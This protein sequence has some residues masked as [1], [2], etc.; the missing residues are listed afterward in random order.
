MKVHMTENLR[1]DL[2]SE[3]WECR[4]CGRELVCARDN[5][6]RG[7]NVYERDPRE[8]HAPI[9]D[10]EKYDFTFSPDPEWVRILE[11]YCP[12]CGTQMEVEYLP[13]GHPPVH[14]IDLDLDA[15]KRQWAARE[16]LPEP[17]IAPKNTVS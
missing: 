9:I 5:Y 4:K 13:P 11:Y 2:E 14:D 12:G 3:M 8:I 17:V 10:A 1:I 7:L 15:M 16:E 6:K